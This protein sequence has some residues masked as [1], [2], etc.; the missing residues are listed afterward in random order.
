MK[1][2]RAKTLIFDFI[3][4]MIDDKDRISLEQHLSECKSCEVMASG[5]TASLDLLHRVPPVQPDENFTWKVRLRLARE[6]H[7]MPDPSAQRT[8]LRSWNRRF[9]LSAASTLVVVL[10]AGYLITQNAAVPGEPPT[11]ATVP[12]MQKNEPV[13]VATPGKKWDRQG[14]PLPSNGPTLVSS[15]GRTATDGAGHGALEEMSSP[16]N[17][18]S[19]IGHFLDSELKRHRMRRL[20]QQVELLQHE[21]RAC[22]QSE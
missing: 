20:E 4:G 14:L 1:C 6:R 8:W 9:A 11:R 22:E 12:G 7:L 10:T 3:D 16:L 18:D 21:L 17:T 2:R 19:L 15:G 5:M 13:N